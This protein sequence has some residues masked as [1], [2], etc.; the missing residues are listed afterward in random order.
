MLH[1]YSVVNMCVRARCSMNVERCPRDF[2]TK[3]SMNINRCQIYA[4]LNYFM[5]VDWQQ[6]DF[7]NYIIIVDWCQNR[8]MSYINVKVPKTCYDHMLHYCRVVLK[9]FYNYA[10]RE[11]RHMPDGWITLCSVNV[12]RFQ[13]KCYAYVL[14][15]C[16]LVPNKS[17]IANLSTTNRTVKRFLNSIGTN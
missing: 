3:C 17:Y 2:T 4:T 14:C 7:Y 8:F 9:L 1:E 15:K 5:N 11:C 13:S 16:R 12:Y 6:C 10:F